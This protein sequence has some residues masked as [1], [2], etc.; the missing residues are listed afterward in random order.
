MCVIVG[1][2][3]LSRFGAM[4]DCEGQRVVLLTSCGGEVI[5]YGKGTRVGSTFYLATK[6]RRYLQHGCTGYLVYV[7]DT[8]VEKEVLVSDV[9]IVKEFPDVF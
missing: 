6:A 9:P 3:L 4:I 2:D 8:Q 5:I 7:V 1:I